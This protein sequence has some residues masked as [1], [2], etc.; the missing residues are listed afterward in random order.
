MFVVTQKHNLLPKHDICGHRS[1]FG[2]D[3]QSVLLRSPSAHGQG[4]EQIHK[5]E[6]ITKCAKSNRLQPRNRNNLK[7][8]IV[9]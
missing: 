1:N 8:Q 7:L 6:Q 9:T 4:H 2:N 3:I 5:T